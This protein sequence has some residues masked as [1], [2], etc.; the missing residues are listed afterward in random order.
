MDRSE[1]IT[2]S[3]AT[4]ADAAKIREIQEAGWIS[5][6]VSEVNKITTQDIKDREFTT[7]EKI[8]ELKDRIAEN[9]NCWKATVDGKIVGYTTPS[10]REGKHRVGSMYIHP[11]YQR[12]G[13]G[14]KLMEKV[15]ETHEGHDIYLN[16]ATYNDAAKNFYKKHG[17]EETGE[18]KDYP[19]NEEQI[20]PT[21]EM[22][23]KAD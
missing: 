20:I 8:Q 13:I 14:A 16:V 21:V 11:N 15:L 18:T 17:F 1:N 4:P 19:L 2:I 5:A 7:K 10:V 22:V 12:Q 6:Y 3:K 23:K 9:E